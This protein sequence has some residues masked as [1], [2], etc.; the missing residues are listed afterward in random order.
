MDNIKTSEKSYHPAFVLKK[1]QKQRGQSMVE[2]SIVT[3]FC[4][5]VLVYK[6]SDEQMVIVELANALKNFYNAF[7]FALSYSS[8]I[9]PL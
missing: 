3:A 5:M 4:V 1:I 2:Y 9:M 6:G 7:A 8:T